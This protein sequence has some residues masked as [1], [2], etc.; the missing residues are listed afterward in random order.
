MKR[1]IIAGLLLATGCSDYGI[2]KI[3]PDIGEGAEELPDPETADPELVTNEV[4]ILDPPIQAEEDEEVEEPVEE[5]E[6]EP[7]GGTLTDD[8]DL[9]GY[10]PEDG[11][12]DDDNPVIHPFAGD[13]YGDGV[14]QDCDLLD[15][16]ADASGDMYYAFCPDERLNWSESF[17]LCVDHGYDA[18]GSVY[19]ESA[20]ISFNLLLQDSGLEDQESP[21]VD[22]NP[23]GD[24]H[25]GSGEPV[26][27]TNWAEGEPNGGADFCGHI[28]RD[29]DGNGRWND[30]PC[31]DTVW[32][33]T[34]QVSL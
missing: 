31:S 27:Y 26:S 24:G 18:L 33:L 19:D 32:S 7:C 28:N 10:T 17:D 30:V 29:F 23:V 1:S 2:E 21:W 34:C 8:C 14:D 3:P 20:Q 12:C 4:E 25:W 9:D 5:P 15:C 16:E 11:D 6:E 13:T 22:M